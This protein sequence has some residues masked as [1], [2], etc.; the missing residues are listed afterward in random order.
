[1]VSIA[2]PSVG[3]RPAEPV[4]GPPVIPDF[5][6]VPRV[7]LALAAVVFV[8]LIVAVAVNS[9]WPLVFFHVAF[10]AGWTI[11]DLLVG[12]VIGAMQVATLVIMTKLASF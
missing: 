12:L 2:S 11:V 4:G 6:V 9:L 10:G 7:G 5:K 1:M 8:G 3:E